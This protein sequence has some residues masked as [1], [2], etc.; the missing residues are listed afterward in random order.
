M[1]FSLHLQ[2]ISTFVRQNKAK[3][4]G[5]KNHPYTYTRTVLDICLFALELDCGSVLAKGVLKTQSM[6]IY[7][8]TYIKGHEVVRCCKHMLFAF[9][10]GYN[11][12]LVSNVRS[13]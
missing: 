11:I 8:Y 2:T 7:I 12:S 9:S 13:Q 1:N 4:Q 5:G 6:H 3:S 10:H